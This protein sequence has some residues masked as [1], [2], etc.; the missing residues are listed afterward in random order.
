MYK[1]EIDNDVKVVLITVGGYFNEE[2]GKELINE[3]KKVVKEIKPKQY[4]LI[5]DPS[6]LKSSYS[7]I[8]STIRNAFKLF[9]KAGFKEIIIIEKESF[10][11]EM[12]LGK[13]EKKIFLSV[14]KIIPSLEEALKQISG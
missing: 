8:E 13:I 9:I 11:D 1:I 10:L 7:D 14:I 4:S 2:Q 12:N 3:Y 6:S 5:L